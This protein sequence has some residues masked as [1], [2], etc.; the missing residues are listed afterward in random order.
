MKQGWFAILLL[1]AACATTPVGE[2]VTG[3]ALMDLVRGNTMEGQGAEGFAFRTYVAP[4]LEQR[5]SARAPNGTETRF[6][7]TIRPDA[8]GFCSQSP[9][10]RGGQERCFEVWREGTT[11]RTYW[12]G[13]L[14]TT[15]TIR[16]GNPFEL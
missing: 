16:Q 12:N 9:A 3:E 4:D 5:G 10:L 15:M 8:H 6:A 7:G 11:L 13:A 14:W 1:L 2:R